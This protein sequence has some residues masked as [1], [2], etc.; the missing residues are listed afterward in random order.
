MNTTNQR[1]KDFISNLTPEDNELIEDILN[2]KS[3]WIERSTNL[4]NLKSQYNFSERDLVKIL[5][6]S[7]GEVHRMLKVGKL[8]ETTKNL[9]KSL[10]IDKWTIFAW[11]DIK[12]I[13]LYEKIRLNIFRGHVSTRREIKGILCQ[14]GN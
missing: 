12:N 9:L 8:S 4:Y 7:K 5:L 2:V 6:I 14:H 3:H 13:D 10:S 11:L 1:I